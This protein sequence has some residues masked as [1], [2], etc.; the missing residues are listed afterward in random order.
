MANKGFWPGYDLIFFDCDSTL[1]SVEGIDELANLKGKGWRVSILTERAMGGQLDISE[2]YERRLQAIRPT[3]EEVRRIARI[4]RDNVVPDVQ[5]VIGALQ[6]LDRQ[7]FI[8]SAGMADA[9]IRFG[10]S[11]GVPRD[12]IRAVE[13][14]YDQL[15]G[16]W[17]DFYEHRYSGNPDARY[18]MHDNGPLTVSRGKAEVVRSLAEGHFGRRLLVGDGASDLDARDAVDL[19]VGFGGV[20]RR[21]RV[22]DEAPVFINTHSLTPILPLAAGPVGYRRCLGTPYA[23]LFEQGLASIARGEVAFHQDGRREA[24]L[25][26]F[27][28]MPK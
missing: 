28:P 23:E 9:V 26:A 19:F 11:L 12:H 7:V 15:A 3:L 22:A 6:F 17:W 21:E 16:K 24:F 2:V 13:L 1:T 14:E 27:D 25:A 18:L 20:V 4:Y 5:A 10:A 8:I